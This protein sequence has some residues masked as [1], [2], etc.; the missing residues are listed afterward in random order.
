MTPNASKLESS[1]HASNSRI[2]PDFYSVDPGHRCSIAGRSQSYAATQSPSRRMSGQA[3]SG[4]GGDAS[5]RWGLASDCLIWTFPGLSAGS[6]DCSARL[7]DNERR[8]AVSRDRRNDAVLDAGTCQMRDNAGMARWPR[9]ARLLSPPECPGCCGS[10][11]SGPLFVLPTARVGG[12]RW[13]DTGTPL[14]CSFLRPAPYMYGA[15]CFV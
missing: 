5:A 11:Q 10:P 1:N 2:R 6:D 14:A 7:H 3:G 8:A 12:L 13:R 15:G 4:L 9:M